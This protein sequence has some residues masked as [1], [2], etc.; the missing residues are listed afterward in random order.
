MMLAA[1]NGVGIGSFVFLWQLVNYALVPT[2]GNLISV[3]V[4]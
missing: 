3:S 1:L 2:W 4:A